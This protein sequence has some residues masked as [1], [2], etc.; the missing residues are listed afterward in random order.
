[1]I[2]SDYHTEVWL[3][4]EVSTRDLIIDDNGGGL[5][6]RGINK[7]ECDNLFIT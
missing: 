5:I 1:M 6:L 3:S 7:T 2:N 4:P